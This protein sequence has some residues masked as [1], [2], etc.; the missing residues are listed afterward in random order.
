M[1][2]HGRRDIISHHTLIE[3]LKSTLT[4]KPIGVLEQRPSV[5]DFLIESEGSGLEIG[6]KSVNNRL[7][8]VLRNE[9]SFV[10][11]QHEINPLRC[12]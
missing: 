1:C 10:C 3:S 7:I 4:I 8:D 6:F 2:S 11:F 5:N 9:A 12:S